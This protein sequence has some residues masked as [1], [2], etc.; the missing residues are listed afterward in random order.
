[1]LPETVNLLCRSTLFR[2][3]YYSLIPCVSPIDTRETVRIESKRFDYEIYSYLWK[4]VLLT[5]GHYIL[6]Q[7]RSMSMPCVGKRVGK[8]FAYNL[9]GVY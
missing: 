8:I 6:F 2:S 4:L 7:Y 9:F 1:M 3:T 5:S